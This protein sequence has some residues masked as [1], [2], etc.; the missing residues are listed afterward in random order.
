MR[1]EI[2]AELIREGAQAWRDPA[3]VDRILNARFERHLEARVMEL[4]GAVSDGVAA[5]IGAGAETTSATL[6][7]EAITAA[8]DAM[9][10]AGQRIAGAVTRDSLSLSARIRVLDARTV[11]GMR[12]QIVASAQAQETVLDLAERLLD[13]DRL[14]VQLPEY[15]EALAEAA[16]DGELASAVRAWSGRLEAL[17]EIDAA[18]GTLHGDYTIRSATKRLVS[19]LRRAG[20]DD[21]GTAVDRWVLERARHQARVVARNETVEAFR[22]GYQASTRGEPHVK[23][24][25][26]QLSGR[27]PKPDPCDL[28]ANQDIYGLGPGGYPVDSVPSTPHPLCLCTQTAIVDDG[29]FRRQLALARGDA[30]PPRP[31]ESD[32]RE[33]AAE[34]LGQQ[35]RAYQRALLGPTRAD[36]FANEPER[37]VGPLGEL[38]PVHQVMGRPPPGRGVRT[39][40][41]LARDARRTRLVVVED[42]ARMVQPRPP[43]RGA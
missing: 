5:G 39:A 11:E 22:D 12:R 35:P 8:P 3:V 40:R 41:E 7:V 20:P 6:G 14:A 33:T 25:R 31:W 29:H 16:A 15:V 34:W 1:R 2:V 38:R 17:G 10:L 24:Y 37:V 19:D 32:T 28:L 36:V 30:E 27:H 18:A 9:L 23:G 13:R 43:T 4:A 26:W 21:I 42:R